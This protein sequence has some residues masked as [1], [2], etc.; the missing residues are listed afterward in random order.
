MSQENRKSESEVSPERIE[1]FYIANKA[2]FYQSE[3]LHLRQ[4]ILTSSGDS[5]SGAQQARANEIIAKLEKGARFSDLAREYAKTRLAFKGGDWGWIERKDIRSELSE[6]AFSSG[7]RPVQPS[8]SIH[9]AIFILYAEAV[10]KE[11]IQPISQ[12]PDRTGTHGS[13]Y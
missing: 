11:M 5:D 8:H 7:A 6:V 2:R 3:A 1:A 13:N 10:R 12:V 4:I 9:N